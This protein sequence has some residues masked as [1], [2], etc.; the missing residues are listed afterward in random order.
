MIKGV[1]QSIVVFNDS[2]LQFSEVRVGRWKVGFPISVNVICYYEC[3][4]T[5]RFGINLNTKSMASS[6]QITIQC[7]IRLIKPNSRKEISLEVLIDTDNI[8]TID[9]TPSYP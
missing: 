3:K 5:V 4:R 2:V 6:N 1:H 9:I 8:K 7:G